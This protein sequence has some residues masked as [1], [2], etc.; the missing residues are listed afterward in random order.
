MNTCRKINISAEKQGR[1]PCR[2]H[3]HMNTKESHTKK[4]G[5]K[6]PEHGMDPL[7]SVSNQMD[8]KVKKG[9]DQ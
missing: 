5:G 9:R 8:K 7:F 2:S 4:E 1:N 3:Q 6:L